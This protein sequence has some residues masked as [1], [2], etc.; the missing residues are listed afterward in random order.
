MTQGVAP[1][2]HLVH[3]PSLW[4]GPAATGGHMLLGSARV[5]TGEEQETR[6][7]EGS[8]A[9]WSFGGHIR[10][11]DRGTAIACELQRSCVRSCAPAPAGA[12]DTHQ[13][14]AR[15]A[16]R[17]RRRATHGVRWDTAARGAPEGSAGP[18][19]WQ[20]GR[21]PPP[22]GS[23]SRAWTPVPPSE[24]RQKDEARPGR[25]GAGAPY[26]R[27]LRATPRGSTGRGP[28]GAGQVRGGVRSG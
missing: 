7:Q 21:A 11:S 20:A 6:R 16:R 2:I 5:S 28:A 8:G 14:W 4:Q 22:P 13:R 26:A 17:D 3:T 1:C 25:P 12:H 27:G 10:Q 9:Q 19:G 18:G 15:P 23:T 24:T